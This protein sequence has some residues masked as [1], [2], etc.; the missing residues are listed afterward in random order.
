M[1]GIFLRGDVCVRSCLVKF[2]KWNEYPLK[3]C[4]LEDYVPFE[5]GPLFRWLSFIFRGYIVYSCELIRSMWWKWSGKKSQV[6][7]AGDLV[8][9]LSPPNPGFT[10]MLVQL[11]T[12]CGGFVSE[13]KWGQIC[14]PELLEIKN[15]WKQLELHRSWSFILPQVG[16]ITHNSFSTTR[17]FLKFEMDPNNK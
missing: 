10:T 5:R 7:R 1:R 11:G 6:W 2:K 15:S 3:K 16:E 13:K 17:T 14:K 8:L 9:N 4:W 12:I